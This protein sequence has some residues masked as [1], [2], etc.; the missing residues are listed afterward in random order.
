MQ[1]K[2]WKSEWLIGWCAAPMLSRTKQQPAERCHQP[3]AKSGLTD[4]LDNVG[5][6]DPPRSHRHW[7]LWKTTAL[8]PRKGS[9]SSLLFDNSMEKVVFYIL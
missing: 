7:H 8:K 1:I 9:R 6:Q 2:S 4:F 5:K 3:S